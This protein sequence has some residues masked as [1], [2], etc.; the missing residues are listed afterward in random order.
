MADKIEMTVD[1]QGQTARKQGE[2][3]TV[4][5]DVTKE[6]AARLVGA[7]FAKLVGTTSRST[8]TRKTTKETRG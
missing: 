1:M 4:G 7:G 2:E 3:L 6:E 8:T 5:K